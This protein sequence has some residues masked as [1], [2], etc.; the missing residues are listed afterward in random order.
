[1]DEFGN[2]L[3]RVYIYASFH[4]T[5]APMTSFPLPTLTIE[6]ESPLDVH[7]CKNPPAV[8]PFSYVHLKS[9]GP[10]PTGTSSTGRHISR[11]KS[12]AHHT[13]MLFYT[14]TYHIQQATL[15]QLEGG[16]QSVST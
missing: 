10:H 4:H 3:L 16:I 11:A 5:H 7:Q 6:P 8:N 15:A 12:M 2:I 14:H 1:M 9:S 13:T